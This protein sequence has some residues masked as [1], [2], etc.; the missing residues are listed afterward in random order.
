MA[1]KCHENFSVEKRKDILRKAKRY[2]LCFKYGHQAYT[3]SS[4]H[5]CEVCKKKHHQSLCERNTADMNTSMEG[6]GHAIT[7]T[8]K[9]NSTVVMLT[10]RKLVFGN[11][12]MK[13]V[14]VAILFDSGSQKSYVTESLQKKLGLQV[15]KTETMN[16]NTFGT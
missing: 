10:A 13:K 4:R 7:A 5:R 9:S 15:E 3:C 14:P 16:L 8:A 2:F 1:A 6:N 11:D 12:A